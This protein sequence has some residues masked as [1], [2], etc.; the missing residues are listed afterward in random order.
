MNTS[1]QKISECDQYWIDKVIDLHYQEMYEALRDGWAEI[2]D[3]TFDAWE[4]DEDD[5]EFYEDDV[6]DQIDDLFRISETYKMFNQTLL[7]SAKSQIQNQ[8][9][10][11]GR[12]CPNTDDLHQFEDPKGV[13][14]VE[15]LR[16]KLKMK[17]E[18]KRD[19]DSHATAVDD[20]PSV[21]DG[22]ILTVDDMLQEIR[23]R[24][25]GTSVQ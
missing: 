12:A 15:F 10:I 1:N 8:D 22:S 25:I 18:K 13:I 20:E 3:L 16:E 9:C 19:R 24:R 5:E 23:R 4:C 7:D 6:A 14:S 11:E 2:N 21:T 17:M